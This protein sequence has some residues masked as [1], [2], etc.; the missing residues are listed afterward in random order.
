MTLKEKLDI[1]MIKYQYETL[2]NINDVDSICLRIITD[3]VETGFADS[4]VAFDMKEIHIEISIKENDYLPE[5]TFVYP[6]N[7]TDDFDSVEHA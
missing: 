1:I 6:I 3:L 2:S 4:M 5:E 7:I